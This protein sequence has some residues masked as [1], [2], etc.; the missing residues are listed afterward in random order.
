MIKNVYITTK[1]K[2]KHIMSVDTYSR[3]LCLVEAIQIINQKAKT[4]KIDLDKNDKW[5]KPISLQK[6]I[7]ERYPSMNH[8]VRVEEHLV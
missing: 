1:S 6:Y 8:D 7:K 4:S 5:I 2:Q 3:W